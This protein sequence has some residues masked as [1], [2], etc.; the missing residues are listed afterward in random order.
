MIGRGAMARLTSIAGVAGLT[1]IAVASLASG[2]KPLPVH[3]STTITGVSLLTQPI[4]DSAPDAEQLRRGQYLVRAG[5]CVSCHM[6]EGG[7]PLAGGLGLKTPFGTIYSS[8][9]SADQETGVGNW[10]PDQ[11]YRAMHDGVGVHGENLYPAFPYPWFRRASRADDDAILAYLKSTPAVR[12][13]PPANR[14]PFPLNI[15]FMIKGWNLLF[16][17]SKDFQPD[18]NQSAA[19]NRGA[20]LVEGLAHCGGCHTPKNLLGADKAGKA[21]HGGDLDN[22]VAPDLTANVRTGLGDWSAD[23]ITEYLSAGRNAHANA[24][25]AMADVITYSTSLMTD[26]DRQAIV[27]Y[28]ETQPASPTAPVISIDGGTMRRGA[29]IYSDACAACHLENGVGQPRYIPPLDHNAMLQQTD[30]TGV[31]HLILAGSR[32]GDSPSRPS[33]LAMPSFAWKLSDQ[34]VADV[35]TFIRNAWDNQAT[36][37][38]ANEIA[39]VRRTL[40]LE[41]P[42]LTD[43]S[44]DQN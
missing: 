5:D 14:L 2:Q 15:R 21:F 28:L 10:T 20:Y 41:K 38:Q 12:Y 37:V 16:L 4:P 9:I 8:N 18:P 17:R 13:T 30:P 27:A 39:T 1:V 43:N 33:P 24:G 6:R 32:T 26:A 34:E 29:A 36:P 23:D 35:A 11:F 44:G 19:W 42:R 40:H 25:G 7:E 22:W 31:V 3:P